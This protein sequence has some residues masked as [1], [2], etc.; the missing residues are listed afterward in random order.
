MI[1]RRVKHGNIKHILFVEEATQETVC[2]QN[3]HA[4]DVII[5]NKV[6]DNGNTLN[7]HKDEPVQMF[8]FYLKYTEINYIL[9]SHL[10]FTKTNYLMPAFHRSSAVFEQIPSPLLW[11]KTADHFTGGRYIGAK[12]IACLSRD[13]T[14]QSIQIRGLSDFATVFKQSIVTVLL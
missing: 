10:L 13:L 1:A 4:N 2:L 12:F 3:Y 11:Q 7:I 5:E 14:S 6:V 8:T 9:H